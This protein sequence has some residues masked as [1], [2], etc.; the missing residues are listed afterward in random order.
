MDLFAQSSGLPATGAAIREFLGS[1]RFDRPWAFLFFVVPILIAMIQLLAMRRS[2]RNVA[3][4]GNPAAIAALRTEPRFT[5]RGARFILAWAWLLIVFGTAGPRWG[6]GADDGIAVGRDVVLVLDLSRSMSADDSAG[7]AV[8]WQSAI[9]GANDLVESLHGRGGHRVTVIVFAARPKLLVPLTTDTDHVRTV[10]QSLD[11]THLPPEI[12]PGPTSL[13]SG[14][15]IGSALLAAVDAHDS[16]FPGSQDIILVSDGDDPADDREWEAGVSS[17]RAARIPIHTVGVGDPER[18]S[19][20]LIDGRLLE[21]P[22]PGGVP[23]PVQ[24]QLRED[25][26]QAIASEGRGIY[27]PARRAVPRLGE[28]FRTQIE[29][30]PSRELTDD[31]LPQPRDRSAW[32]LG[33]GVILLVFGWLKE[34]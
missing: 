17:A 8:R 30:N 15:R 22:G 3:V 23:S 12:R 32:F 31:A 10:L 6:I 2:R 29:P 33:S 7:P 26:L 19:S 34:R 11:G 25:V 1:V 18:P 16:R 24:T 28:F 21:F 14:T 13:E 27:L 9:A 20:I 4:L 5:K